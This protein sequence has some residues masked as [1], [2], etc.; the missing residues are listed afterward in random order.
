MLFKFP[1]PP[2]FI[3]E[4]GAPTFTKSQSVSP[5]AYLIDEV[6]QLSLHIKDLN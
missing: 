1:D 4:A 6:V 5:V 2:L 3:A